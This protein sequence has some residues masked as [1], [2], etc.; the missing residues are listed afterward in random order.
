MASDGL[1]ERLAE[2]QA[3]YL[4]TSDGLQERLAERE[5]RLGFH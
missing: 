3:R 4:M 1:Q 5:I 2:L